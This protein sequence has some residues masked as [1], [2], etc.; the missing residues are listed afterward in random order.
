MALPP[1]RANHHVPE[2][3]EVASSAAQHG[4]AGDHP[5]ADTDVAECDLARTEF[6]LLAAGAVTG[7]GQAVPMFSRT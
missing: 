5:A 2:L 1:V 3:A 4:T 6:R 7:G